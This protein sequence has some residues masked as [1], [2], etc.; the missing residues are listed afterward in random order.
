MLSRFFRCVYVYVWRWRH[1]F[2]RGHPAGLVDTSEQTNERT[3]AWS[4]AGCF[5]HRLQR[6]IPAVKAVK[7]LEFQLFLKKDYI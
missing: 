2:R 4:T 3:N 7:S 5:M 6:F 1:L